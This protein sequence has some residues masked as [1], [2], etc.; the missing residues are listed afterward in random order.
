MPLSSAISYV[1]KRSRKMVQ[2]KHADDIS[3][4]PKYKI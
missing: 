1:E 3:V 4:A 2:V